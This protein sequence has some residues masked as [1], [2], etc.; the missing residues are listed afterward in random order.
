MSRVLLAAYSN[1][2]WTSTKYHDGFTEGFA[3]ALKRSGNE[4]LI[5]HL[6]G[7]L[8]EQ[9]SNKP[10]DKFDGMLIRE[11]VANFD[12]DLII[13]FNNSMPCEDIAEVTDCPI[14]IY[15]A[16]TPAL[17]ADKERIKKY[18]D[19]YYFLNG[20]RIIAGDVEERFSPSS[21]RMIFFGHATDMRAADLE[22][23]NNITYIGSMP[24]HSY[25]FINFFEQLNLIEHD[26]N[27]KNDVKNAFFRA[28]DDI[29]QH[30]FT[31]DFDFDF[32]EYYSS[33]MENFAEF[34]ALCLYSC[35]NKF[36]ILSRL[37]DLG[38]KIHGFPWSWP[39]AMQFNFDLFRHFDYRLS[40]SMDQN[41]INFNSSKISLNMPNATQ[42]EGLSWR[43]TDILATNS[44]L[45]TKSR[46]PWR[47]CS[48]GTSN[49]Q[50]T[51]RPRRRET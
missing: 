22:Q 11:T 24:N 40:V 10:K 13:T 43:V 15:S 3:R 38:L 20:S 18:I 17:Y 4:V 26:D 49:F 8:A 44:V 47:K 48:V 34:S 33:D 16:D 21:K 29:G 1:V 14:A 2:T 50:P 28:L 23:I 45:L 41:T 35:K 9:F 46:T 51:S 31:K 37:T 32:S 36:E 39:Y 19:R 5:F 27:K 25:A 7:L 6:N 42:K 12:P 30:E